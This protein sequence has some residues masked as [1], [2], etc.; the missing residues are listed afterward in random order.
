MS[1]LFTLTQ[2]NAKICGQIQAQI[3]TYSSGKFQILLDNLLLARAHSLK[4]L[5]SVTSF[6]HEKFHLTA[7]RKVI[8]SLTA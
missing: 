3:P 8:V 6:V 4:F 5:L 1:K 7:V 2:M